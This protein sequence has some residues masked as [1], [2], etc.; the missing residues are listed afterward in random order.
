VPEVSMVLMH[1]SC[2]DHVLMSCVEIQNAIFILGHGVKELALYIHHMLCED[3][4]Q[5]HWFGLSLQTF[6][7]LLPLL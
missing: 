5:I 6:L 2:P 4:V 1:P 7:L 3:T